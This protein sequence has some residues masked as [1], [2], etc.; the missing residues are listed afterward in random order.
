M[1]ERVAVADRGDD[2]E[3]VVAQQPRQAVAQEREI[4]GDHDPHGITARIVVGPPGRARDLERAVERLDAAAR[5]RAGPLPDRIGAAAAVV[6]DLDDERL[7]A[8]ARTSMSTCSACA[9]LPAF[10][11]ASATTK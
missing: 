1:H 3:A 8:A 4:F 10:A 7:A 9:C 11:S 6:D 2:V 5:A